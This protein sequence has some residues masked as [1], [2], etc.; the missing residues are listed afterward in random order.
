MDDDVQI[1]RLARDYAHKARSEAH[2]K[3]AGIAK[4]ALA[5]RGLPP[6]SGSVVSGFLPFRTEINVLPLLSR[7]SGEGWTLAL[8]V[9]VGKGVP[10]LFRA[11]RHGEATTPG[12]WGIPV[13]VETAE[14]VLPDVLL[15]PL[16]NFDRQGFRLG[17][18]GGFYDR[19]L[20]KLRGLKDIVAIGVAY[21]AQEVDAV[22]RGPYDQPLEW[23]MTEAETIK[24]G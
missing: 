16:L 3:Q 2:E 19:T 6:V 10:L 20:S 17:Y 21:A 18:G 11:W 13:P 12:V 7:L 22:P 9:V 14:E 1:K 15:V 8:P 24:C 23:V 4:R 5:E